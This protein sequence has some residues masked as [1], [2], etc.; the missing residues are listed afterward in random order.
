MIDLRNLETFLWVARLGG[1]R[2]AAEH[3]NTTQPAI[4]AR[5]ALLERDLDVRLFENRPRRGVL[6]ASGLEL[7]HYAE[8]ILALREEMVHTVGGAATHRGVLRIGVPE[9]IVHTWLALLV[10]RIALDYPSLTLDIEVDSSPNLRDALS[11][12]RLDLAM[13]HGPCSDPRLRSEL[14]CC[15]PL[16]WMAGE[17]LAD[18]PRKP[19]FP[20]LAA[21]PIVTS[22]RGSP[23]YVAIRSLLDQHG[24]TS[25]R[26]FGSSAIAGIVRMALDGIGTCVLPPAVVQNELR[27]GRLRP[28][29][30]DAE[31]PMLDFYISF[32]RE[33][34][35]P[36]ARVVSDLAMEVARNYL[37]GFDSA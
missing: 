8:R 24:F 14:L 16:A 11:A 17:A 30:I 27:D 1:F 10:E 7:M 5:I 25:A 22:R 18:L 35:V 2:L 15:F 12:E 34:E 26:M 29:E 31:L 9:T 20:A 36:L 33:T 23:A 6:T 3:L 4:S 13:T 37:Q 21:F 19:G 32:P 28:L